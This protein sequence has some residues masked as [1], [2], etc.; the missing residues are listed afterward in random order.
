MKENFDNYCLRCCQL[1]C[2]CTAFH[3]VQ[4]LE[5][6]ST[7]TS[8]YTIKANLCCYGRVNNCCGATC[9]KNDAVFDILD[10]DGN[11]AATIQKTYGPGSGACCRCC[12][13]YNNYVMKFPASSTATERALLMVALFQLDYHLFEKK[14]ND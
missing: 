2:L 11:V 3:D 13:M 9:C 10:L 1:M 4:V 8:K 7:F 5:G 6:N 12:Y 14:G